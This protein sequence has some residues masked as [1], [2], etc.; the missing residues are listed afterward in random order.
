[1][2]PTKVSSGWIHDRGVLVGL[3]GLLTVL[4]V[5]SVAGLWYQRGDMLA[6]ITAGL[7][8]ALIASGL[9]LVRE[10]RSRAAVIERALRREIEQHS[11]IFE[12]TLDL[13]LITDRQGQF[14]RVSPS[15]SAILGYRPEEMIGRIGIDFIHPDDLE[16]TRNEMR[17][18]RRGRAMRNFETRYVHKDGRTVTLTWTGVWS[19]P[20]QLHFFIGR[21][22]TAQK[23]L[24]VAER[25]AK[26]TLTAVIDASPVAIL[27]LAPD[28]T[29]LVWSR[30]AEE[31][32]GYAADETLGRPYRLVPAGQEPEYD[33]LFGRALA[34]ETLAIFA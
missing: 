27:C 32:F 21:D 34:G 5:I 3:V 26:E 1:M 17:L 23:R 7:V 13:I 24:E 28:R 10:S 14:I 8:V 9:V 29:V 20:E 22:M 33:N 12:T 19:E 30:A 18:A 11:R 25:N 6:G 16:S 2:H 31:I 15:V 4:L